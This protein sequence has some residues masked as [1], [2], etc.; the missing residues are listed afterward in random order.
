MIVSQCTIYVIGNFL[1]SILTIIYIYDFAERLNPDVWPV[2]LITS[3]FLLYFSRSINFFIYY[4]F[5]KIFRNIFMNIF[6]AKIRSF[7]RRFRSNAIDTL[8]MN[9]TQTIADARYDTKPKLNP[10]ET[11]FE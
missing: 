3:N 11:L 5:N 9:T 8:I 2:I 7:K 4:H 10:L 6:T 1:D